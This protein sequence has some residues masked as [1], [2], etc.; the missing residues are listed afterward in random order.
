MLDMEIE[1]MGVVLKNK[2]WKIKKKHFIILVLANL[3]FKVNVAIS[4][5]VNPVQFL[6]S[7]THIETKNLSSYTFIQTPNEMLK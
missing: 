6:Q 4:Q 5:P 2:W 3:V 7:I 1:V